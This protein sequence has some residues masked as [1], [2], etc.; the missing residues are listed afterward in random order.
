MN[1]SDSRYGLWRF[2]F[3][4]RRSRWPPHHRNGSP[5]LGSKSSKNMP[6]LLP[7]KSMNA[8]SVISASTQRPSPSDHRVG[9]SNSV[10]EA[11]CRF[12]CITGLLSCCVE[13]LDPVLPQTPL[14]HA[15]GAYGQF[16][17][18]D[19]NPL[20]FTTV[21]ANGQIGLLINK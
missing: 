2:R 19:F 13:T 14:P 10:Y 17:K 1:P 16:P 18:R 4:I 3:L 8:I 7:R 5:A 21:T 9:S 20:D 12:T 6:T 15:T 11:T